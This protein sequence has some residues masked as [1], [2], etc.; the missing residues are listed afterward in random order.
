MAALKAARLGRTPAASA[1][2]MAP[3]R[4]RSL[5]RSLDYFY[6][7]CDASRLAALEDA[8]EAFIDGGAAELASELAPSVLAL[9][10]RVA[11]AA[12]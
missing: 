1:R 12:R 2:A 4:L 11:A 7:G 3:A 8:Q 9:I 10:T 5:F 6:A